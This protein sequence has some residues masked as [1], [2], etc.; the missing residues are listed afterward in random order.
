MIVRALSMLA[1]LVILRLRGLPVVWTVHN[2]APHE[3]RHPRLERATMRLVARLAT[4]LHV[5]SRWAGERV[6]L[7]LRM[8]ERDKLMVGHHGNYI[9]SYGAASSRS[10]SRRALGLPESAHIYLIFG[11][12]RAYKRIPEAIGAFRRLKDSDAL[13]IVAGRVED[14][15]LRERIE[16]AAGED[17]RVILQFG[18]VAEEEVAGLFGAADA[19]I[20]NYAEVFSSGA[21]MAALST[22]TPVVAP[23]G[24]TTSEIAAPPAVEPFEPGGLALA[25]RGVVDGDQQARRR[26]A[27]AAAELCDWDTLAKQLAVAFQAGTGRSSGRLRSADVKRA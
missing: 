9:E 27:L 4:T 12:I 23:A 11:A 17:P 8:R 19:A 15:S 25:L 13:L 5:H 16:G 24:G 1:S 7:E 18:F 26:A 21:L 22:G 20:L 10:T 2:L 14:D 3:P 6:V